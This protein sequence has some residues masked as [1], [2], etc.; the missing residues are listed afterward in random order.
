MRCQDAH[1]RVTVEMPATL[2]QAAKV[3]AAERGETFADLV[4]RA[5]ARELRAQSRP[6]RSGRVCLPLV[7]RAVGPRVSMTNAAIEAALAAEDIDKHAG[8]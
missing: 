4:T 5:V 6:T 2:V 1:M 8:R 7:G 3:R